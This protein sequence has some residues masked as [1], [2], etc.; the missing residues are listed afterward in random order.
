VHIGLVLRTDDYLYEWRKDSLTHIG[1]QPIET[2]RLLLRRY[3]IAD[4]D[5]MFRNWVTDPEVSRFWGWKPHENIE[6][7]RSKLQGW[8]NDYA[9][10]DNYHW[11]IVVK[12]LTEAI[13]Y[14]YLN[15]IDNEERSASIHYLVSRRFWNQGIVT[16]ACRAVLSFC[17]NEVGITRI[18]TNH[19]VDNPASGRVMQKSGMRYLE[20]KHKEIPDCAQ[21]SGDYC[22]YEATLDDWIR[23]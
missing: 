16:E 2:D 15:E 10:A 18:H 9:K 11:V 6:E 14:I 17:F 13:G 5:D 21:I 4:A 12:E 1:T 19:H 7:T 20:T 8:I 22:F 23:T 3:E